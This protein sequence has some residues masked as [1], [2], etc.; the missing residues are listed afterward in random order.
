MPTS[1]E[2]IGPLDKAEFR[3][4]HRGEVPTSG[5]LHHFRGTRYKGLDGKWTYFQYII[6]GVGA[7]SADEN[8]AWHDWMERRD[9]ALY[10]KII[11]E[12]DEWYNADVVAPAF[13][14][15]PVKLTEDGSLDKAWI[16]ETVKIA[17]EALKISNPTELKDL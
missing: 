3:P 16:N 11:E 15:I 12:A 4:P 5:V 8:I 2:V 6:K 14:T 10:Q 7:S 1:A 13:T 9:S 17:Q